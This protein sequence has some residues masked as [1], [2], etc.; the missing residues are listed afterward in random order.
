MEMDPPSSASQETN[1]NPLE[2]YRIKGLPDSFYYIPD[3]IT[4]EEEASILSKIPPTAGPP[5]PTAA[6][7]P[8]PPP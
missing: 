6:S 4:V 3:F 7:N 2:P 8:T 1:S 5:S